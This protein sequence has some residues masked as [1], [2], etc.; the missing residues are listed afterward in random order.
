MPPPVDVM[1]K[2]RQ[3]MAKLRVVV[4]CHP[5][6]EVAIREAVGRLE[7]PGLV[8]VTPSGFI[9]RGQAFVCRPVTPDERPVS[10]LP[11]EH[12]FVKDDVAAV[13]PAGA[14]APA[15]PN[16]ADVN[17]G[18]PL[19]GSIFL[20]LSAWDAAL[21]E[22]AREFVRGYARA[23]ERTVGQLAAAGH[24]VVRCRWCEGSAHLTYWRGC[25]G[26]EVLSDTVDDYDTT[27]GIP[28]GVLF[29]MPYPPPVLG[30][31]TIRPVL[32]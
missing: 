7:F 15:V 24:R 16:G 3:L 9:E 23:T 32:P 29:V 28:V 25:V 10:L 6:D 20:P 31:P 21:Q 14:A 26:F 2:I 1:G 19:A 30:G 22:R 18:G 5:D 12:P 11:F 13:A 8:D 4:I 17:G 27:P